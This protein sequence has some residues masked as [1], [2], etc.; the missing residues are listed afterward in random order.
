M[1][2][3]FEKLLYAT[4]L[5]DKP[6]CW[7]SDPFSSG[8]CCYLGNSDVNDD[9]CLWTLGINQIF[10]G[11]NLTYAIHQRPVTKIKKMGERN[12]SVKSVLKQ[13]V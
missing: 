10:G 7:H 8:D 5:D 11:N 3:K 6:V 12:V 9:S 4:M 2:E 1:A 13:L